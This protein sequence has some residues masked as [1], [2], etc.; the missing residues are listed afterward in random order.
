ME[1]LVKEKGRKGGRKETAA[2]VW[3]CLEMINIEST[4]KEKEN[5]LLNQSDKSHF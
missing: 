4:L 3:C 1:K 2:E 5:K